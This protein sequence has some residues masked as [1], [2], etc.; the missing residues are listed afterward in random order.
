M[1]S[2]VE[3]CNRALTKLGQGRI[4]SILD[5]TKAAKACNAIYDSVRDNLFRMHAWNFLMTRVSLAPLST[6][7]SHEYLYEYQLPSDC[8][9][10]M[11]I[12]ESEGY[13]WVVEGRKI[14]TNQGTEIKIRYM[15]RDTDPNQYDSAFIGVLA[16]YLAFELA[17]E[18][19]Q[20]N[21]K[22]EAA[23]R[24]FR[25]SLNMAKMADAQEGTPST[26]VED[27]WI[28]IRF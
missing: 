4:T 13:P 6:T 19:T 7:P 11:D 26:F 21:T 18:L 28:N 3:T 24:D 1:A 12:Y 20:S 10:I 14:M 2:V 9:R 8:I 22:K 27:E 15:K 23:A 17:E 25:E 5:D 16:D